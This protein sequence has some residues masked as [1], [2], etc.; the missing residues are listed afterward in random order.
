MKRILIITIALGLTV[1]VG[2][3]VFTPSVRAQS[4]ERAERDL[5]ST[6][7]GLREAASTTNRDAKALQEHLA[8]SDAQN[9]TLQGDVKEFLKTTKRLAALRDELRQD[10]NELDAATNRTIAQ[11]DQERDMITDPVTKNAMTALRT[12]AR[13]E[14]NDRRNDARAALSQLDRVLRQGNDVAHA[15]KC[16]MLADELHTSTARIDDERRRATEEANSYTTMTNDL[17]TKLTTT[18]E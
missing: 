14:A 9:D 11:F 6:E 15:A 4:V 7:Q 2:R 12:T 18:P 16:V 10:I 17:L 13:Q 8:T 5:T 3:A 1:L